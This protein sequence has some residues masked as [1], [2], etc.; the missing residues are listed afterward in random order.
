[1]VG[2][3][4]GFRAMNCARFVPRRGLTPIIVLGAA[5]WMGIRVALVVDMICGE[6]TAPPVARVVGRYV[7]VGKIVGQDCDPAA[8]TSWMFASCPWLVALRMGLPSTM[9]VA[10]LVVAGV[11]CVAV[12][13]TVFACNE[14][15]GILKA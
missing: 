13:C 3:T 8:A 1:M 14:E 12:A 9:E 2:P 5:S 6:R 11:T 10:V 7:I 4:T 15:T